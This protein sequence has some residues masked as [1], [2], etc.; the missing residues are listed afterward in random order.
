MILNSYMF[1]LCVTEYIVVW[2][3]EYK[4]MHDVYNVK[5]TFLYTGWR[6]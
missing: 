1:L 5:Y 3:T 2:R 4:K 6:K